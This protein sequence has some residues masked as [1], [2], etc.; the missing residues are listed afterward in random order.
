MVIT[1]TERVIDELR[2][3]ILDGKYAPGR[4][5]Q[6][7]ALA[8]ELDV[9]RTPI[10][11]ALRVL[12]N[13]DLLVYYPNRGYVVRDI[14]I[15][16]VLDAFDARGALEGMACRIAAERGISHEQQ[17]VLE[18]VIAKGD[19]IF[20]SP[21]WT[22]TEQAAWRALNAE[23][24][25]ALLD[26]ARNRHLAPLLEQIRRFPRM[27]DARLE[28]ESEFFQQIYTRE[29]RMRSHGEH[30]QIIGAIVRREGSRAESLM[31][32]HVYHN[33][34]VLRRGLEANERAVREAA[35]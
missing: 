22:E 31:R 26:I 8:T 25:R 30:I 34:E 20:A 23:F 27:F 18:S 7:A 1:V 4:H 29:Q 17:A 21:E 9:S 13:E 14:D 11:D 35:E 5:L 12:A 3:R 32:E 10:R 28:P 6:E 16:D 15:T 2:E 33:R 19:E 24:H